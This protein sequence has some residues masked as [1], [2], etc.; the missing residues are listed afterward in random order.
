MPDIVSTTPSQLD[1]VECQC[2]IGQRQTTGSRAAR[3]SSPG[4]I[5][6]YRLTDDANGIDDR[7]TVPPATD[8]L[9]DMGGTERSGGHLRG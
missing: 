9:L 4:D 5:R 8:L 7:A 1:E 3:E 2:P 6:R